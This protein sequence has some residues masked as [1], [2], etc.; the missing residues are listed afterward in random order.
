M[1]LAFLELGKGY[2]WNINCEILLKEGVE[3]VLTEK[4]HRLL[5]LLI[6]KKSKVISYLDITITVWEDA[7][8][9]EVSIDSVKNQVRNLRQKLPVGIIDSVYGKGYMLR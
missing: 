7:Y 8:D 9:R 4:E 6:S 5:K 1:T 2:L 3:V